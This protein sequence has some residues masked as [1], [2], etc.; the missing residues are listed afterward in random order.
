MQQP[1]PKSPMLQQH[2][3]RQQNQRRRKPPL[4][5]PRYQHWKFNWTY[6]AQL[7][8]CCWW[9]LL[10]G[11]ALYD[12]LLLNSNASSTAL[13]RPLAATITTSVRN[14][15]LIIFKFI[16]NF[17]NS[18]LPCRWTRCCWLQPRQYWPLI[19]SFVS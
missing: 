3:G 11:R 10:V 14:I 1:K 18:T 5:E 2:Q 17:A 4:N 15:P 7:L 19:R 6:R 12:S 9:I 16:E 13:S 8:F